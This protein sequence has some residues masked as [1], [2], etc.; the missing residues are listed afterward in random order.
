ME[1]R[2]SATYLLSKFIEN[3]KGASIMAVIH[4]NSNIS[5]ARRDFVRSG[6]ILA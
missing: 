3:L 6:A 4:D 2:N 5:I 1:L